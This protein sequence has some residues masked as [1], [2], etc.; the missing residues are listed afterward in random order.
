MIPKMRLLENYKQWDFFVF[1]VLTLL[2]LFNESTSV[3]YV[4]YFFWWNELIRIII[5]K[6]F[7]K[8]NTNIISRDVVKA[9]IWD[10]FFNLEF[11]LFLLLSFLESLPIGI[12]KKCYSPMWKF[13]SLKI[14]FSIVT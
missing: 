7:S 10:H 12:I 2:A 14:G 9:P 4:I 11:T 1:A 6:L 8:R 3:F 13:Y 5:D